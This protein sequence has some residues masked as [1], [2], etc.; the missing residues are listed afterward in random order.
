MTTDLEF[1]PVRLYG[2]TPFDHQLFA[3]DDEDDIDEDEDEEDDD[4]DDDDEDEDDD[5]EAEDVDD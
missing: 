1:D 4:E 2:P 5:E 3:A